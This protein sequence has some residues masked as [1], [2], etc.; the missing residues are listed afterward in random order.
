MS[1]SAKQIDFMNRPFDRTL[2]VA[3]GTPRNGE[4]TACIPRVYKLLKT[5]KDNKFLVVGA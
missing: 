3:A 1:L 5:P 4:N 2:E